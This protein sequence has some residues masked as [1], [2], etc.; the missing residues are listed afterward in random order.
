MEDKHKQAEG[1][2]NC[3]QC[4]AAYMLG[5]PVSAVPDFEKAGADAWESFEAFFAN[6]GFTAEMFPPTVE[7]V[8]DYLASGDTSRETSH[9]VVMR[10]GELLHDPHP[11]NAGLKSVQ[12]VWLIARRAGPNAGIELPM[13]AREET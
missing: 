3:M 4:A 10:G 2:K 12:A 11:S 1:S 9:M 6:R 5:L 7:I 13:A 8:G